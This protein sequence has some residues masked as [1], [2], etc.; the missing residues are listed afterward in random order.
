M[1]SGQQQ[2]TSKMRKLLYVPIIHVDSD[3]G[4]IAPAIDKRST[5]ICGK[6]RW[7]R[8]KQIVSTFWDNI[9]EYFKKQDAGNLKIYQDGL[10]ADGELG[11]KII[12]EGAQK[13]SRNYRIVLELI[14]RG[15]EIRK[16][17]DVALLKEEYNRILKLAQSKSLW[18]RTTAYIGYRFHKGRLMM[19]RDKFIAGTI[20][21][22]LKEEEI[23]VL[24][25]G[26]YHDVIPLLA[27]DIAIEE[28]KK[29]E[30]VR[31]YFKML[32]S[33][34]DKE[35]FDELAEYLVDRGQ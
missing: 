10:M 14:R 6:E 13:G 35:R 5:Q 2:T 9:E 26:A 7:E 3:L 25:I 20:N 33:G 11:Q 19:K 12:E 4:S 22:T 21:Q 29:T 15:A 18:E 17:E 32:I 16:T 23:G 27:D 34:G 1:N 30:K 31:E 8:H 24:F 28:V